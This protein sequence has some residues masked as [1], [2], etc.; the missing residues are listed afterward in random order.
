[1]TLPVWDWQFLI[2]SAIALGALLTLG[3]QFLPARRGSDGQPSAKPSG[4]AHCAS[5]AEN[6]STASARPAGRTVMT[7]VVSLD[8]LRDT[9]RQVKH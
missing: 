1:M 9:A 7:Q 6:A 3:R 5:N 8:D 4:C 2:V